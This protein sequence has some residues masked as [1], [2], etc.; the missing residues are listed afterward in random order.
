MR[1][2]PW[3]CPN[4]GKVTNEPYRDTCKL[5]GAPRPFKLIDHWDGPQLVPVSR[6]PLFK[7]VSASC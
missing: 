2:D 4:C 3:L 6:H 7:V 5:C 1:P